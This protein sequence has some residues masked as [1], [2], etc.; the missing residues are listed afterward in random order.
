MTARRVTPGKT[1]EFIETFGRAP[2]K[3][4]EEIRDKFRAVYACTDVN[5]PDVVL[6]FGLFDGTIDEMRA[7]QQL[8]ERSEQLDEIDPLIE[9][10]L[11]DGSF[12]VM[13]NLVE[14]RFATAGS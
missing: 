1:D 8:G 2:E 10:V 11:F 13:Q 9:D 6:T 14:T 3:M 5:D 7:M 4:P 12:E